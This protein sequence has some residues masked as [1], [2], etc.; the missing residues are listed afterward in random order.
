MVVEFPEM[1]NTFWIGAN[2]SVDVQTGAATQVLQLVFREEDA[3]TW[4]EETAREYLSF[5]RRSADRFG[6]NIEW[7][8][9][10]SSTRRGFW[11]IKGVQGV[12]NV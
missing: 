1:T 4:K 10:P 2:I 6:S 11:V 5:W 3:T 9:E 7:M 8:I 12:Q